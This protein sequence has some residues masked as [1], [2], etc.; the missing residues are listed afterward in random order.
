MCIHALQVRVALIAGLA[1][2]HKCFP[3]NVAHAF[4][5]PPTSFSILVPGN[6][7][8]IQVRPVWREDKPPDR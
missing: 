6:T 2:A 8:N 3:G 7:R 4:R 5:S 1:E